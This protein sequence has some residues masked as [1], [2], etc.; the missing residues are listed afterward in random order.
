MS[1]LRAALRATP[2][3]DPR[4]G[5][6]PLQGQVHKAQKVV[7][8][9][10]QETPGTQEGEVGGGVGCRSPLRNVPF[11]NQQQKLVSLESPLSKGLT[12]AF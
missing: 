4:S 6:T 11:A 5:N 10:P 7:G 12:D 9:K 2:C 1:P 8:R 3:G